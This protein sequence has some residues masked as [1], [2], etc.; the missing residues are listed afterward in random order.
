[1]ANRDSETE[2]GTDRER[3]RDRDSERVGMAIDTKITVTP[4]SDILV[5]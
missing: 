5:I 2:T 3:N 1:M 4:G